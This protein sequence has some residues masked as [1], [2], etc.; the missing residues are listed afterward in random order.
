MMKGIVTRIWNMKMAPVYQVWYPLPP[1][2]REDLNG[3]P[4]SAYTLVLTYQC[5][6]SLGMCI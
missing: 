1:P 5:E 4:V 3:L 6:V 2:G